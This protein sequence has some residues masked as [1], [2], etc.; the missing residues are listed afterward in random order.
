MLFKFVEFSPW[1]LVGVLGR[2][3]Q[4][5]LLAG[6]TKH[7]VLVFFCKG[8]KMSTDNEIRVLKWFFK[9]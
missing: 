9:D 5:G 2:A 3:G 7:L 6:P 1:I 4:L 8:L